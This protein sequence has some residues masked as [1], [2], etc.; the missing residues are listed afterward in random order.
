MDQGIHGVISGLVSSVIVYPID[1]I[2][3]RYQAGKKIEINKQLYNGMSREILSNIPSSFVYWSV[4]YKCRDQNLSSVQSV[5]IS[6][7]L[8]NITEI[9]LDIIKKRMQL[10]ENRGNIYKY[11]MYHLSISLVYNMIYI[12]CLETCKEKYKYGNILS[13]GISSSISSII[14]YP[15]DLWKTN[16]IVPSQ[17]KLWKGLGTRIIYGNL[18]SGIYMNLFLWLNNNRI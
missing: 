17:T 1:T 6:S 15:F 9:P 2:K 7:I 11:G 13:V 8:S 18:Y 3:T 4:Y 14:S 10:G 16:S 5:I 12:K